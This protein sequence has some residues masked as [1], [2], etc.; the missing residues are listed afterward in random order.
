MELKP[1]IAGLVESIRDNRTDGASLLARQAVEA[2]RQAAVMSRAADGAGLLEELQAVAGA[3]RRARPAMAPVGN[4]VS[5]LMETLAGMVCPAA[6]G[7]RGRRWSGPRRGWSRNPSGRP[8]A[9]SGP[10]PLW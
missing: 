2:V 9:S 1:E 5:R 6:S 7:K 3:L 4:I 10:S 8:A